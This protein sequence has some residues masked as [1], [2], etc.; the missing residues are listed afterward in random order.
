MQGEEEL[1]HWDSVASATPVGSLGSSPVPGSHSFLGS[2]PLTRFRNNSPHSQIALFK[3]EP[4]VEA[5]SDDSMGAEEKAGQGEAGNMET[6][7]ELAE[8]ADTLLLLH[9]SG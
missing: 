7:E 4:I 6:D 9:E 2:S 1:S 8:M 3:R 5:D